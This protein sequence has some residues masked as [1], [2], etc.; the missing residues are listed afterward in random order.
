M[1]NGKAQGSRQPQR[2]V[3]RLKNEVIF[4]G[5]ACSTIREPGLQCQ[6]GTKHMCLL[7]L[8]TCLVTT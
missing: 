7:G 3:Q 4:I 5:A 1:W 8:Y 2:R 6:G